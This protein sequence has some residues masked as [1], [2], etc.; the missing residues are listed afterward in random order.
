MKRKNEKKKFHFAPLVRT[1]PL[2]LG[3]GVIGFTIFSV[4][5]LPLAFSLLNGARYAA[6]LPGKKPG[7]SGLR[8]KE[9]TAK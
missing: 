6:E 5:S 2:I 1:S 9:A 3:E 4:H 7:P 8:L